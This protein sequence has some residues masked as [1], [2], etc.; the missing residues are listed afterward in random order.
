MDGEVVV[1]WAFDQPADGGCRVF[2]WEEAGGCTVTMRMATACAA[3]S[4]S[5][6]AWYSARSTW[7]QAA[8]LLGRGYKT[9]Y[10]RHG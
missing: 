7:L 9:F 10:E 2:E 1:W 4:V 8:L 5:L 3:L 6:S